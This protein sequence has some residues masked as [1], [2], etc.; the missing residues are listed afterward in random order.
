LPPYNQLYVGGDKPID[1]RLVGQKSVRTEELLAPDC[2][3]PLPLPSCP[4]AWLL[5]WLGFSCEPPGRPPGCCEQ[6][7]T[8]RAIAPEKYD[9]VLCVSFTSF[10]FQ[11]V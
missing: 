3:G 1:G 10:R 8:G 7:Q 11:R 6:R 2:P 9:P 5:P 4:G